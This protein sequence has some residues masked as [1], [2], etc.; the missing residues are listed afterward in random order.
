MGP[1]GQDG[2][3]ET[4]DHV[5][6][7]NSNG[8]GGPGLPTMRRASSTELLKRVASCE[9]LAKGGTGEDQEEQ[10]ELQGSSVKVMK[11][12]K[13]A[14]CVDPEVDTQ[15]R[16][17]GHLFHGRCL[18]PWLQAA[19]GPPKCLT[20]GAMISS[21]VLAIPSPMP[22]Q[23]PPGLMGG[24]I[25]S[26]ASSENLLQDAPTIEGDDDSAAAAPPTFHPFS[27]MPKPLDSMTTDQPQPVKSEHSPQGAQLD[28]QPATTT[29]A[30]ATDGESESRNADAVT[31]D[32]KH[33][34]VE[35][36]KGAAPQDETNADAQAAGGDEP[37]SK[38]PRL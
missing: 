13:C 33:T 5:G 19:K 37:D 31:E 38:R 34:D 30:A 17:C 32:V 21:C 7:G 9:L 16:P 11:T 22:Q 4:P 8:V 2:W 36:V 12:A 27:S 1:S 18:K 3:A 6:I 20:C 35:E 15:L 14:F 10:N 23:Q 25:P 29:T 28:A 24:G 26:S